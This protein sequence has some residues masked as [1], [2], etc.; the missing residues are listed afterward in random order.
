MSWDFACPDWV[1]RLKAGR[2][3]VPDLPLD[4]DEAERAVQDLQQAAPAGCAG[5]AGDGRGGRR[6]VPRHRP[7]RLRLARQGV[8]D[9]PERCRRSSRWCRRRTPR[10]PAAPAIAVTAMLINERP[11]AEMLLVGPTQDV[12]DLAFQQALGHDRG[13]SEA[14]CRSASMFA[15]HLKTI[16]DRRERGEAEDQDL[17]H[18]GDDRRQAGVVHRRRAACDVGL[19]LCQP[20]DRPDP[21]RLAAEPGEPPDV[22]HHPER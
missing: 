7:R 1:E 16:E 13:R 9:A 15:E 19:F 21:R 18:A 11:R 17:R 4:H 12:A 5:A 22:H 20:G 6:M 14:I 10:P 8:G 3:L 2:S